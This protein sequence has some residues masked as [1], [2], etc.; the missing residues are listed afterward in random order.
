MI[1]S[2]LVH[3]VLTLGVLTFNLLRSPRILSNTLWPFWR[4]TY[5]L[6]IVA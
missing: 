5:Y 4:I 2:P 6:I 3:N 1:S